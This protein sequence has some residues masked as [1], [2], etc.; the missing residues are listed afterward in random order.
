[1]TRLCFAD[2]VVIGLLPLTIN[3]SNPT[4]PVPDSPAHPVFS[5]KHD[6]GIPAGMVIY[7][8][9]LNAGRNVYIFGS[10]GPIWSQNFSSNKR[11]P[12]IAAASSL[13]FET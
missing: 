8:S 1:V 10:R 5:G 11:A 12:A 9:R 6:A 13:S 3:N 4:R 7:R 2:Q